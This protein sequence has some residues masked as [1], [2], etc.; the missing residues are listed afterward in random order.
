MVAMYMMDPPLYLEVLSHPQG[1]LSYDIV[2]SSFYPRF[3]YVDE[4]ISKR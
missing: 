4:W 2:P 1:K 3:F